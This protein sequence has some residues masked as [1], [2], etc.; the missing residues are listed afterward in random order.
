MTNDP[1]ENQINV[2][3][4]ETHALLQILST[5]GKGG[6][7]GNARGVKQYKGEL[8]AAV[9]QPTSTTRASSG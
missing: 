3:D 8:V 5:N 4:A 2:Y 6:V 9:H 1:I 7:G